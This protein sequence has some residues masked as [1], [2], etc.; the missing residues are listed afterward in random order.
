M[1]FINA[2][3]ATSGYKKGNPVY[4]M[5][6]TLVATL[7]GLL[8]GYDTAVVNGAEK[9]LVEFYISKILVP[10]NYFSDTV[11]VITQYRSILVLVLYIVVIIVCGQVIKLVGTKK[12]GLTIAIIL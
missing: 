8:F 7:G 9:S 10:T 11:P 12:G 6:L 4:I 5:L 1:A 2:T 3:S